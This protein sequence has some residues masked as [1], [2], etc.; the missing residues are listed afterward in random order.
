MI[1]AVK[2]DDDDKSGAAEAEADGTDDSLLIN[3]GLQT[4]GQQL[5]IEEKYG[6]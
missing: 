4:W 3:P 1:P 6:F 5:S 2:W